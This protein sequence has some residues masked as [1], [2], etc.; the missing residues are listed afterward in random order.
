MGA[1]VFNDR[2][3]RFWMTSAAACLLLALA[4]GAASAAIV[5][6]GATA[7]PLISPVCPAGVSQ[8]NCTIVLTQVTALEAARDGVAYPTTI[9][10]PGLVVGL[11]LGISALSSNAATVASDIKYLNGTYGG[12]PQA[13]LTVLRPV[14][15][16]SR[17]GWAV[18]AQSA[19]FQL[20]PFLGQVV[21]FP[22]T[23]AL[24][25]VP[26]EVLA[27]TVPTWAPVLSF[28]LSAT[29][30]S[31]RQSRRAKCIHPPSSVLSQSVVGQR[32]RYECAYA[33]TRVEYSATEITTP[34][35][36]AH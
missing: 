15:R 25:V 27:L 32:T 16:R 33:G 20:Q 28:N 22:L 19:D 35:P 5:E 12:A 1:F 13:Q 34:I 3:K 14:G 4:P 24:P 7:S 30:F 31:Y 10:K 17:H 36:G 23:T 26:G 21:Q 18:A 11:S 2:M 9:T 29:Q 8:V 6:V